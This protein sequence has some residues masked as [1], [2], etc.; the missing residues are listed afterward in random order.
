M[1]DQPTNAGILESLG[2]AVQLNIDSLSEEVVLEA[3]N[4]IVNDTR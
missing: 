4:S 2:V 3:I 1:F